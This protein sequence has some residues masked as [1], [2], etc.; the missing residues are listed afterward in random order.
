MYSADAFNLWIH[1]LLYQGKQHPLWLLNIHTISGCIPISM[2]RVTLFSLLLHI[3]KENKNQKHLSAALL[4]GFH[5]CM[6]IVCINNESS[7][8]E[9]EQTKPK[10]NNEKDIVRERQKRLYDSLKKCK[11][12]FPLTY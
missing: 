1:T 5:C 4:S 7:K 2:K 3:I 8:V 10:P 11:C 6:V 12:N 9:K